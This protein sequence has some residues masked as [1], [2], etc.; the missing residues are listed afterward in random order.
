MYV[1]RYIVHG[2]V[3]C[4]PCEELCKLCKVLCKLLYQYYLCLLEFGMGKLGMGK[5]VVL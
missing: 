5:L 2:E 1:L 4:K 3:L